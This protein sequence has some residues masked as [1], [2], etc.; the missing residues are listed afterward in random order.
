MKKSKGL[1]LGL[2]ILLVMGAVSLT[3]CESSCDC[4]ATTSLDGSV[5]FE[6]S[7]CEKPGCDLSESVK[8][9]VPPKPCDCIF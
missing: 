6:Y 9:R 2:I 4:R 1:I 5:V 7:G 3:G 8:N